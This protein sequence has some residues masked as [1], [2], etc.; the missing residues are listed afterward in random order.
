M[1]ITLFSG[2]SSFLLAKPKCTE[3]DLKKS[4]ICPI[5]GQSDPILDAKCSEADLKMS[6]ICPVWGQCDPFWMANLTSL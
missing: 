4:Q 5:W 2:S 3:A 6:Q 1:K